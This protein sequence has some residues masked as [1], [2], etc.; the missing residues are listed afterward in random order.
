MILGALIFVPMF[1]GLLA[2]P[3]ARAHRD[4][5]RWI[6]LAAM[7]IDLALALLIWASHAG[8]ITL[9]THGAWL[10]QTITPWIPRF[11]ISFHL[12]IDGISLLLITLTAFLGI[13]SV[14]CSWREIQERVG[15]YH[16]NLLW[17]LAGAIGVFLAL[18]LFLF[19]FLWELMLVPMYFLIAIWGHEN[20]RYAS[21]KFFIFT[22]GSGLLMLLAILALVFVHY[23]SSGVLTFDY[24]ALL[25]TVMSSQE[26]FWMMLGF[27]VAF[28]VKL[29]AVPLHTWLP[30][31]HTEAPTAGSVILA[32]VLLK[33]GA[34][35]LLRFVVPLFPHAAFDFT[36]IAMMLGVAGILY[37]ALLAFAQTD[38]KRLV[39]YTSVSHLGFVLL[40]VF[41]WNAWALDGAVMQMI[42]HG[43]STGA[44]FV[45]VGALQER[46]HTRDMAR[47]GGLWATMPRLAAVALFFAIASLGLPG[48][49][50][51]V[52]EF[53][54][55]LGSFRVSLVLTVIAAL[56]LITAV[57]YALALVQ[58]TFHGDNRHRWRLPDASARELATLGAMVVVLVW[59]GL[60]PQPVLDVATRATNGLQSIVV[61]Q[62]MADAK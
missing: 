40:G 39:A 56:G 23:R 53:L 24:F 35:G 31:A 8:S 60:Y 6:A 61:G 12:A 15:F 18:D 46:T 22:Q 2:W 21:I 11:G 42:A 62:H 26:A 38:L 54:V 32:G 48:M 57:V 55:L 17:V 30:D 50:N 14:A 45:I 43:I 59:L 58:R 4:L 9:A 41:A 28:A 16:F 10:A 1:A 27:F 7:A 13:V 37:G 47:M 3:A 36:P 33:T 51:F 49:G 25:N 44:L 29:P 52:G 20:R 19:F 5:P 34:Y